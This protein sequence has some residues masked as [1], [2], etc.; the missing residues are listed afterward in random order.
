M[1]R[2]ELIALIQQEFE[3]GETVMFGWDNGEEEYYEE[4]LSDTVS[5][6]TIR[7][8]ETNKDVKCLRMP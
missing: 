1:T 2:E 3:E 7:D 8:S 5:V 4:F 6:G